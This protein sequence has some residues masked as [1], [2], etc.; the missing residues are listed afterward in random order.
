MSEISKF[1]NEDVNK[2]LIGNKCDLEEKREVTYDEGQEM[3]KQFDIPFLEVSAKNSTN[4]EETFTKMAQDILVK[5]MDK[6]KHKPVGGKA[7]TTVLKPPAE[8]EGVNN[9]MKDSKK[10]GCCA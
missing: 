2:L 9:K 10:N 7:G 8:E 1:A 6:K 5:F 4:V 3:A